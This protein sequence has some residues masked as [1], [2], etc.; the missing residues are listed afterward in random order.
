[1]D[2][3]DALGQGNVEPLDPAAALA[4]ARAAEPAAGTVGPGE[5]N[6]LAA[7]D[8][9]TVTPD[10][11]G[12]DPVAGTIAGASEHEIAVRRTDPSLGAV[13]VHFPRVGFRV[14]PA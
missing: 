4:I 6:G 12:F 2:R 7:G 8:A 3:V 13:V 10:D 11:Y 9:V 1:M 5:P 14:A